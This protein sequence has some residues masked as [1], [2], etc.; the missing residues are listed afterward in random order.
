MPGSTT[1]L[2]AQVSIIFVRRIECG[3]GLF[4]LLAVQPFTVGVGRG[5]LSLLL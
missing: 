2:Q 3:C 4:I 1:E 5:S